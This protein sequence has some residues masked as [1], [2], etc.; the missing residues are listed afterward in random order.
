[1]QSNSNSNRSE[2]KSFRSEAPNLSFAAFSQIM[3]NPIYPA[4]NCS[5]PNFSRHRRAE[6]K[7]GDKRKI[8]RN[9]INSIVEQ[10]DFTNSQKTEY[11][12]NP[13]SSNSSGNYR[14]N[15]RVR[16][17]SVEAGE[18]NDP[19][20]RDNVSRMYFRKNRKEES[21]LK[22]EQLRAKKDMPTS[23][24]DQADMNTENGYCSGG[25]FSPKKR[26][27]SDSLREIAMNKAI[28]L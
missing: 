28:K 8:D 3:Q 21:S 18:L 11:P 1:M 17:E 27:A 5:K 6:M 13:L 9:L 15:P 12:E 25:R 23:Y 10:S 24:G 22:E 7:A 20:Y 14:P 4:E 16:F 19:K 26:V 2:M